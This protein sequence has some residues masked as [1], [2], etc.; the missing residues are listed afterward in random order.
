[1]AENLPSYEKLGVFYLGRP[2]DLARSA[3]APAPLLYDSRD[4]VTHAVCVGMTGSGKTGLLIALLEEAAI[5]G[6]PSLVIDPKGDLADLLLTFPDLKPADFAPWVEP[7]EAARQ[8]LTPDELAAREAARWTA[9]LAQWDQDGARIARLREAADFAIYT[10]GS[11]AGLPVSIL[12]SFAAPAPEM[13]ED[14]ELM[15]DRV[16]TL[17]SSLL[18]LLDIDSDPMRGRE[19]IL[20]ATIF[21]T[22]WRAGTSL[23]LA[24][25]IQQIQKPPVD[26]IGVL[27]LE[28]FYPAKE[29]FELAM[30]CNSLLGS[31]GFAAWLTGEPLDVD[32]LLYTPAG[33]PRVAVLSIAHLS[34]RE[35]MFFVSLLLNQTVGWMRAKPGTTSLRAILCMDEVFGY[36]P[37][38][39]EPPSKRPL[40]T[41]LKQARA[42]GL[43][44]VL[45]TQN[46]VDLDY[47]GL[48]NVGT[49]LLG[50]LQTDRDKQRLLDGLEG[51]AAGGGRFD[52]AGMEKTLAGLGNRVF[53]M[54]NV[55]EDAPVV[56]QSRWA[57]S[58]LR[59]PLTRPEIKRLMDPVK[60]KA[61]AAAPAPASA[62]A[63]APAAAAG[64][65]AAA[66][67]VLPP[68]VAQRYLPLRGRP[69]GVVYAPALFGAATVHFVDDKKGIDHAEDV[70]LVAPLREG[71]APDW[72]AAAAVELTRDDLETE[73]AAG[74]RF[75]ALPAEAARAKS[76]D[77]WRK[78]FEDAL[79][80]TRTCDLLRSPSL[81]ALS[82]PGESERDFRIRLG[83]QARQERN[84]QV[85]ELRK[86]YGTRVAQLQERIR[87]AEQN[88]QKQE[89]Q[90][91]Q[92]T[93]STVLSTGTAVLGALFG[94]KTLSVTNISKVSTAMR[95]AGRTLQERQDV[96]Q[97]AETIEALNK[98]LTDL[99]AELEAEVANLQAR[100]DPQKEPL[101]TL[102]LKPRKKDVETRL[103]TLAWAPER[104]E[105]RPGSRV[106]PYPQRLPGPPRERSRR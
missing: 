80:R 28:T 11:T 10:P 78:Q 35:R 88:R 38:V 25:L 75:A 61:Q 106:V 55:H 65:L 79:F 44:L 7:A 105:R 39:A 36:M 62:A 54:H 27:D 95:S 81:G 48:S 45:A 37:P 77:A 32:R 4:L 89:A 70:A 1:M 16:Q 42:F 52:R 63:M 60:G 13:L 20:L 71:E 30:A 8:G 99:N 12:S 69:E 101:E 91:H 46:P 72:Y 14:G 40:L 3:T 74:A 26:R 53:L 103:L 98:Q 57:L 19:H 92:Q 17:V 22:A 9:G 90:A 100:L 87:R 49:W 47:K 34:D 96:S 84:D 24:A 5:D 6:V 85:A 58:Y 41:L 76:Y 66:P 43:G 67:P 82:E 93:W 2:Y 86:S 59:G 83:D 15:R 73:P 50:R 97:A 56:F 33:K 68:E 18:A 102:S 94:R 29:R 104:G 31:P 51:V 64:G 23:D 21:D